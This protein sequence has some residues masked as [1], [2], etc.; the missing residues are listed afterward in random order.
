MPK[1]KHTCTACGYDGLRAPQRSTSGGASHEIC[2]A[3]GFEP[4]FTDDDQ[5]ITAAQWKK[6]WQKNGGPWFSKGIARPKSWKPGSTKD[7][8]KKPAPKPKTKT[9]TAKKKPGG[10]R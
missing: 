7:S 8:L 9:A 6:Q 10:K 4:G 2:P 1:V 5:N 3:C